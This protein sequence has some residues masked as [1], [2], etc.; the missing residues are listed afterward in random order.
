MRGMVG[1]VRGVRVEPVGV[2][3]R[4]YLRPG[5][6]TAVLVVDAILAS[7]LLL[8]FRFSALAPGLSGAIETVLALSALL[9]AGW[10]AAYFGR[11]RSLSNLLAVAALVGLAIKDFVFVGV[12]ALSNTRL[13]WFEG[14]PPHVASLFVAILFLAAAFAPRA[15]R[16]ELSGFVLVGW[17][18]SA[19]LLVAVP[20]AL[21]V[22]SVWPFTGGPRR[23]IGESV[24]M[25]LVAGAGF[26]WVALREGEGTIAA[27]LSAAT[28]LLA[29]AW[30]Y[31]L[32]APQHAAGIVSGR[33]CLRFLAYG[34]I[35]SIAANMRCELRRAQASEA[36]VRERRRLARDLHDSLAQDLA[37]IAAYGDRLAQ[38]TGSAHP[39]VVAARRALE[40]SRGAIIDLSGSTRPSAAAALREVAA[41]LAARHEVT[42]RVDADE[43]DDLPAKEREQLVRIAREAMVNAVEHGGATTISASLK[44]DAHHLSLVVS[45]DGCWA[46]G[47]DALDASHADA[48]RGYGMRT[49]RERAAA[50]G[51]QLI[52]RQ[53]PE[54]GTAVGVIV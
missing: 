28:I 18:L 33:E 5:S 12:P 41:E 8:H 24:G 34:M 30:S 37:F 52:V 50:I 46:K 44:T 3:P 25:V 27:R 4:V 1:S 54:G 49:M 6:R 35:V 14:G 19:V 21:H 10:L 15:R 40:V 20:I 9:S 2:W 13:I 17:V 43:D 29:A 36:V 11:Q 31:D 51:G 47:R 42:I 48:Q 22:L 39:L 16:T 7:F 38:E 23:L 53:R 26:V 45:D 32:I